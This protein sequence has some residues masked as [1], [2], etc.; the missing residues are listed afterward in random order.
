[1]CILIIIGKARN[2]TFKIIQPMNSLLDIKLQQLPDSTNQILNTE[3]EIIANFSHHIQKQRQQVNS[4]FDK[5][6]QSI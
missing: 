2:G 1:M 4:I 3:N 5:L 6:R